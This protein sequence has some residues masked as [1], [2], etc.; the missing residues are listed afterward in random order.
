M[1]KENSVWIIDIILSII[2]KRT[3]KNAT[4]HVTFRS[5]TFAGMVVK[6]SGRSHEY[7]RHNIFQ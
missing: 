2:L 6:I 7:L 1:A 4:F 3:R 5:L